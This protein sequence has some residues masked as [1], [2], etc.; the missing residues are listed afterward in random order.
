[1]AQPF[2]QKESV[3]LPR[4]DLWVTCHFMPTHFLNMSLFAAVGTVIIFREDTTVINFVYHTILVSLLSEASTRRATETTTTF[5][6]AAILTTRLTV[7]RYLEIT[8]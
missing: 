8:K 6:S 2:D 5:D 4:F 3:S 1:M 7:N